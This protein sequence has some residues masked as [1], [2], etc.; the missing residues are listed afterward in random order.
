MRRGGAAK[1]PFVVGDR[2]VAVGFKGN[3]VNRETGGAGISGSGPLAYE[4]SGQC[5]IECGRLFI[6][7][8]ELITDNGSKVTEVYRQVAGGSVEVFYVVK[9][10]ITDGGSLGVIRDSIMKCYAERVERR[11]NTGDPGEI[12]RCDGTGSV[13]GCAV[14][15][16]ADNRLSE[17]GRRPVGGDNA[18]KQIVILPPV[19]W[20]EILT[21]HHKPGGIAKLVGGLQ[22]CP[23][24]GI[25]ADEI[26]ICAGERSAKL[27]GKQCVSA[28]AVV[29]AGC[30]RIVGDPLLPAE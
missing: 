5:G 1:V 22:V 2:R 25:K 21:C 17:P 15:K 30:P 20:N 28:R 9:E 19:C 24:A 6:R 27:R 12:D 3:E 23:K 7:Q 29:K 18:S 14:R 11:V 8:V 26:Y 4:C 10:R 13:A 16:A